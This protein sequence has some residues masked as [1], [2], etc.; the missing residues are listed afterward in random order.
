[1]V[2]FNN[3]VLYTWFQSAV[4]SQLPWIEH[5]WNCFFHYPA[6]WY[7]C[8]VIVSRFKCSMSYEVKDEDKLKW[9][10]NF[11]KILFS[12]FKFCLHWNLK[13]YSSL[14][15]SS[16]SSEAFHLLSSMTQ[17][18]SDWWICE[19]RVRAIFRVEPISSIP[20]FP[21]EKANWMQPIEGDI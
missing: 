8:G 3:R 6:Y 15:I 21:L 2:L 10:F 7:Y 18:I 14:Y 5:T 12:S 11:F 13:Q 1:M 17:N 19:L 16:Y 4:N 20:L 9:L